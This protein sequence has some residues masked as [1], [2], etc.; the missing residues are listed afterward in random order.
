MLSD[1]YF[2]VRL[3]RGSF[4]RLVNNWIKYLGVQAACGSRN[5]YGRLLLSRINSGTWGF[6]HR[7]LEGVDG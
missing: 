7:Q 4:S 2:P 5:G 1:T 3:G 6:L